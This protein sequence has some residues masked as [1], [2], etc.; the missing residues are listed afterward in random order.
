MKTP[1]GL[2]TA[3]GQPLQLG[4]ML[5]KGGEGTVYDVANLPSQAVKVY[6]DKLAQDRR[7]KIMAMCAAGWHSSTS[8]AAFP[9]EPVLTSSG[10][11]AGFTM[12]KAGRR[13]PVHQLYSPT[14]RKNFFPKATFPFL[15]RTALNCAQ[16]MASVHATGCVVGDVNHSGVLIAEDATVTLIDADS[17]Q[18]SYG[19]QLFPCKVGVPEFT[20]PELQGKRLDSVTR[21]QAHDSF[22][23]AVLIFYLLMMGRH[24]FAGRFAGKGDMPVERAIAEARFAYSVRSNEM[25]PPPNMA[26]LKDLPQP[27]ADAF[28]RAFGPAGVN[29][30]RS[31]A[32]EWSRILEASEREIAHCSKGQHHY[33]RVASQ[34]PWCAMQTAYPGFIAFAPPIAVATGAGGT[35]DLAALIAALRAVPDPGPAPDLASLLPSDQPKQG[36]M[37][38]AARRAAS[39]QYSWAIGAGLFGVFLFQTDADQPLLALGAFATSIVLT[40]RAP[41][42]VATIKQA[43]SRSLAAWKAAEADWKNAAGNERFTR[44]RSEGEKLIPQLQAL[45]GEESRR[46]HELDQRRRE[47]QLNRFLERYSINSMKVKGIGSSRKATLKSYGVETAADI[48]RYRLFN[49]PGF[50]PTMVSSLEAWRQSIERR[51]VFNPNEPVNQNDIAA[52]RADIAR[53]RNDLSAK[54]QTA[55]SSLH[56]ANAEIRAF[57]SSVP[58]PTLA[59]WTAWRQAATDG[60]ALEGLSKQF[61]LIGFLGFCAL[62]VGVK[63]VYDAPRLSRPSPPTIQ[64]AEAPR[65]MKTEKHVPAPKPANPL[66]LPKFGKPVPPPKSGPQIATRDSRPSTSEMPPQEAE[67]P[68]EPPIESET[69]IKGEQIDPWGGGA[70]ST[71]PQVP[72]F[73]PPIEI[74]EV[75]NPPPE[76]IPIERQPRHDLA[77]DADAAT[78]WRRLASL[79]YVTPGRV[80]PTDLTNAILKFKSVAKLTTPKLW[81]A[82]IE[83]ALFSASAPKMSALIQSRHLSGSW[84]PQISECKRPAITINSNV[85]AFRGLRCEINEIVAETKK[86][87]KAAIQCADDKGSVMS[88]ETVTVDGKTLIWPNRSATGKFFRCGK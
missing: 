88:P 79:G 69:I 43:L 55:V 59:A 42:S 86:G 21:T 78:I 68:T 66:P 14:D 50:G 45:P 56:R 63:S 29:G 28:E 44:L 3:T 87:A 67:R 33:F 51:F 19:G 81:D 74:T 23:L 65:P 32:A 80:S 73:P 6:L 40:V 13:K 46:I 9:I 57:R 72:P 20:P 25:S 7:E 83:D 71:E 2:R 12:R 47:L 75:V 31:S 52:V 60:S 77:D 26:T 58:T 41:S 64:K 49:I 4:K 48:Q 27:L 16:A 70:R 30:G 24:P 10:S 5:G 8:F 85:I 54:L 18:V 62:S 39:F 34:C 36:P 76:H 61:A 17:F 15:V 22:G 1:V 38:A 53:K 37:A 35:V 84:S 11:F 82:E